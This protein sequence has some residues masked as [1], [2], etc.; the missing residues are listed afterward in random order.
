MTNVTFKV[1]IDKHCN[2]CNEIHPFPTDRIIRY[3]VPTSKDSLKIAHSKAVK[4]LEEEGRGRP[5]Y[6]FHNERNLIDGKK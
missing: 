2:K 3:M 4:Q 1:Y 6:Q 5:L